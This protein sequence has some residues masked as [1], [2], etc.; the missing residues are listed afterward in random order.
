MI[1]DYLLRKNKNTFNMLYNKKDLSLNV[2][3]FMIADNHYRITGTKTG[4]KGVGFAIDT[5]INETNGNTKTIARQ[6]L[7][8]M[9]EKYKATKVK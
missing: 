1:L 7:I 4:L 2:N 8:N 5:I 9:L 3:E 6:S